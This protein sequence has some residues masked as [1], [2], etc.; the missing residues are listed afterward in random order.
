MQIKKRDGS[1]QGFL[2]NFLSNRII[3]APKGAYHYMFIPSYIVYGDRYI[4]MR[5]HTLKYLNLLYINWHK[6]ESKKQFF[7]MRADCSKH[8]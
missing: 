7:Q 3:F 6:S 8:M 1:E 5:L 4:N 2:L